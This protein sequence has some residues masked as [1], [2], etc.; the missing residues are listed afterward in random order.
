MSSN[1]PFEP[2]VV[3]GATSVFDDDVRKLVNTLECANVV[4]FLCGSRMDLQLADG[5]PLTILG[6]V[7]EVQRGASAN[8]LLK[9]P[10]SGV[11]KE[12]LT[13]PTMQLHFTKGDVPCDTL[14]KVL[15]AVDERVKQICVEN[16]KAI[17]KQSKFQ[18]AEY[19]DDEFQPWATRAK[20][21]F[22]RKRKATDED[23]DA[24]LW[25]RCKIQCVEDTSNE[26]A[27]DAATWTVSVKEVGDD[28]NVKEHEDASELRK[29]N[30][31]VR[32]SLE[33]A[34]MTKTGLGMCANLLLREVL[35]VERMP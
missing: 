10:A 31:K 23:A 1:T 11:V 4:E 6:P 25:V 27:Q 15:D 2:K 28:G 29:G 7:M 8:I 34:S 22:S 35:I 17:E 16:I 12:K 21:A 24:P 32:P 30:M 3:I 20:A 26:Q 9:D 19:V 33:V 5:G 18:N 13:K 14:S